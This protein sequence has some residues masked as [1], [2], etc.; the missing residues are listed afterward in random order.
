MSVALISHSDCGRHDT[1][2]GQ[3]E[4]V[5]RLRAITRALR[6]HPAVLMSVTPAEARHATE[7][8]LALAHTRPYIAK[9]RD[10]ARAGGGRHDPASGACDG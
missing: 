1:G 5:G 7:D 3:P 4:H 8:E 6:E 9:V 2:W 10:L